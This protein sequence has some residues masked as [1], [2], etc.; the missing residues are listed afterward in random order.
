M[1]GAHIIYKDVK[2]Y[3][4]EKIANIIVKST[5]SLKSINCPM[6]FNSSAIDEF[7]ILF[8][9]AAKANGISHFKD[10]SELNQKESPRLKWGSKILSMMGIKNVVTDSSIKIYGNPNLQINKKIIIKN[11]LKDHRVF[12]TSVIAALTFGGEWIIHDKDSIKTSFPSFLK[13]INKIN[14]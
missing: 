13:I 7:L 5:N 8:L 11:Y 14:K 9:I 12:M 10:L 1:M 3:K 6:H 4:G 2:I